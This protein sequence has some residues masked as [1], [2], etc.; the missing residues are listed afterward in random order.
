MNVEQALFLGKNKLKKANIESY[1][2]DAELL[3]MH[4]ISFTKVQLYT[5]K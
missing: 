5:K 1:A 2:I 3:L 4:I